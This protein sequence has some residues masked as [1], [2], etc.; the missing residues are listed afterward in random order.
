MLNAPEVYDAVV[1]YPNTVLSGLSQVGGFW[2]IVSVAAF[3][4]SYINQFIFTR[5]RH[6][7][8]VEDIAYNSASDQ[9]TRKV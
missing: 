9:T 8:G 3:F 2:A 7:T 4:N 1:L 5:F 6:R